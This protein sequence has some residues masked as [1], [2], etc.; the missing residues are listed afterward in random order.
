MAQKKQTCKAIKVRKPRHKYVNR[1]RLG[2]TSYVCCTNKPP[3]SKQ[4]ILFKGN[5]SFHTINRAVEPQLALMDYW[6]KY[7]NQD[8]VRG[9]I[10]S[11]VSLDQLKLVRTDAGKSGS[12]R[13]MLNAINNVLNAK[14]EDWGKLQL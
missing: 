10:P 6:I 5:G 14:G 3:S 9:S 2:V 7:Y 8:A 1:V 13:C 12:M 11:C 4:S